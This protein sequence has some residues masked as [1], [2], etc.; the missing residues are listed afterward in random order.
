MNKIIT[1]AA[2]L[3]LVLV[4][5]MVI[6]PLA[7]AAPPIKRPMDMLEATIEGGSPETVDYSWCYDTASGEI[8]FNTMDTLIMF[9]GEHSDQYIPS[10]AYAWSLTPLN[11]GL[12]IDSGLP[13]SGLSFENPDNQTGPNAIYY[14]RY[15]FKINTSVVFQPPYSYPLTTEDVAYSFQRTMVQDRV[16]GPQWMLQEPLLDNAVGDDASAGGI[17]DLTNQTQVHELGM[18][19][20]KSVQF[21]A[22]DVW[23]NI[24]FPGA[25]APFLQILTQ[26]WSAIESKQWI[27]NQVIKGAGRPDWSGDWTKVATGMT[28]DHTEWVE[29][30]NPTISPLDDPFPMSY[31][32]G[33][34]ILTPGTPDYNSNF[35][36]MTRYAGY[37]RGWPADFPV[38]AGAGPG[39][40]VNTVEVT[41]NYVWSARKALFLAGDCDFVA[42]PSLAYMPEMYQSSNPPYDPPNYPL[43]GIRVIHP[44]PQ[45]SVDANFFTFD[46]STATLYGPIGSPGVFDPSN[47]PSDFFGNPTWGIHVRKAFAYAFDYASFIQQAALGEGSVPA[48]ALIPGLADYDPTVA[49]YSYDLA[50]ATAEFNQVPG[51]MST[52]FTLTLLYNT[53]NLERQVACTLLKTAL[54]SINSKFTIKVADVPWRTYLRAAVYQ[55]LPCFIIGWLVDFP[56][57]HDFV[58]PFYHTGG[59]FASWQA[60]SNET[61]D[62]LIDKGINTPEGPARAAVYH[63]VEV[64]A[65]QD[66]PS[67]TIIQPV[68]RHFERDWVQGYYYNAIY[69]GAYYY[70]RWKWYYTPAAQLSTYTQP[71]GYNL[72]ADVNYDGKVDMKD[73]GTV[74]RAFGTSYGPPVGARWVYRADV[75]NDRKVDM[76]DIG[77][78]AKQFG[79]SS[80]KWTSGFSVVVSPIGTLENVTTARTPVTFTS[81]ISGGVSPFTYQWFQNDNGTSFVAITG[82]TSSTYTY[83]ATTPLSIGDTAVESFYV[84][85]TD[86]ST[87]VA[88][89]TQSSVAYV[90]LVT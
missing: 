89:T 30:H 77:Y 55:Q 68:G 5:S 62:A 88:Q 33:P 59:A 26:Q 14:Y 32:S 24:M 50:K 82:A 16:S 3:S 53:G 63:D 1:I 83:P 21:N 86:H 45:L 70:N 39:G 90:N 51:L 56:D 67:F 35:W 27:N 47:I 44:L 18:L 65:I 25:Y 42:L 75:N 54:Q 49:G 43:S 61:L 58:L 52:G 78:V 46:I 29:H 15:D 13:I 34:F 71:Q 20:D 57:P 87:P 23:F 84:L 80:A 40:Y 76:K 4:A 73:I 85:V 48:T 74:A 6:T 66:V 12:G 28:L 36:A 64:A 38:L 7:L 69:P 79:G 37:F 10:V 60:Y 22:T 2:I 72:P 41:W 11:G 9:N 8:L 17:A 19:I 81:T 31:G